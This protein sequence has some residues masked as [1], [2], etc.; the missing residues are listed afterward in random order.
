MHKFIGAASRRTAGVAAGVILTGGLVGGVLLAPGTA[1]AAQATT[2]TMSAT[3]QGSAI[4]VTVSVALTGATGTVIGPVSVS[5]GAAGSCH[6]WISGSGSCDITNVP[7]GTY[8]VTAT[9]EG[10][11]DFGSSTASQSD[12]TV[13]G[14][15][16]ATPAV[17]S[18]P[19][20]VAASPPLTATDGQAYGYTFRA[21][22]SP[23]PSYALSGAPGWLTINSYTG[24]VS[25]TVPDWTHSSFSYSVVASNG[26][27]P[28]AN[29]GPFYVNVRPG[30]GYGYGYVNINTN[31]RCTRYVFNGQ[32][33]YCTLTVTNDGYSVAR[34][35]TA[36]I[37]LPWQLR[38]DYTGYYSGYRI[39]GNT[40]SENLGT[41]YPGQNEELSVT[42]T[43]R[44][45]FGLWGSH[46]G[47]RLTVQVVGSASSSG[48][49]GNLWF[50]GQR[51]SYSVAYVTII[52]RG[53]WW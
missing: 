8:T 42:F 30:Y 21:N 20:F 14:T 13:V 4:D 39:Y 10:F 35:V 16:A 15:P 37:T 27:Q 44:S 49:Y 18:A 9:Y 38:A 53:F 31:L 36:Q 48:N 33:G 22:G 34:D 45:G 26:I 28:A 52:P 7:A 47:H 51:Q 3:A 17:T 50:T 2:T 40:V 43:A 23:A 46:P 1:Y 6:T 12:V 29:A 41:L 32:R 5:D 19:V 25:G 11:G 24:T